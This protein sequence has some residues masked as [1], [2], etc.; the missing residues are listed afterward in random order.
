M[1]AFH[2]TF[3]FFSPS[4]SSV[5]LHHFL[6]FR[7]LLMCMIPAFRLSCSPADG[8]SGTELSLSRQEGERSALHVEWKKQREMERR[9]RE[10][11]E[12]ERVDG[13][14]EPLTAE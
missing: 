5:V 14:S 13:F 4:A 10:E 11:E 3:E 1:S 8:H 2:S 9:E 12:E 6:S 7:S